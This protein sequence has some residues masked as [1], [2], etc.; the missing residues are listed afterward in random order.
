MPDKQQQ[1][2][3][4]Q[5]TAAAQANADATRATVVKPGPAGKQQTV[6]TPAFT[7]PTVPEYVT[8]VAIKPDGHHAAEPIAVPIEDAFPSEQTADG[9]YVIDSHGGRIPARV[10]QGP[11]SPVPAALR[12]VEGIPIAP[13]GPEPKKK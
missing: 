3:A 13:S 8:G 11:I 4:A 6:T 10:M 12:P 1:D 7:A 5:N 2:E 9:E